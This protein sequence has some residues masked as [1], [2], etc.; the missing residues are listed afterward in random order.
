MKY[1]GLP[2]KVFDWV[3]DPF[4]GL[5]GTGYLLPRKKNTHLL[6]KPHNLMDFRK[7]TSPPCHINMHTLDEE[8]LIEVEY[9][10]SRSLSRELVGANVSGVRQET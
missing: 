5:K 2:P 4:E 6:I 8:V 9:G 1:L 7:L 10:I 3:T